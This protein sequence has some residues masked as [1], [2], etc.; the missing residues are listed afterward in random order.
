MQESDYVKNTCVLAD[1]I[2]QPRFGLDLSRVAKKLAPSILLISIITKSSVIIL[3]CV[4]YVSPIV[5]SYPVVSV[6]ILY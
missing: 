6:V 4:G 2:G 3:L 5:A 1:M